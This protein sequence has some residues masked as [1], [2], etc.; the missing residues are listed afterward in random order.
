[1]RAALLLLAA[2][3]GLAG[4][5][6]EARFL[7]E[8]RRVGPNGEIVAADSAGTPREIISPA[9]IRNGFTS[10]HLV[11]KGPPG[12]SFMLYI[13][14]N[15]D[16]VLRP[17]LYRVTAPDR[18][19]PVKGLSESGKFNEHGVGLYWLDIWTPG[20]T[21]V[22]RIRVEA[23]LNV[24]KDFV[25]TPLELRVQ[26]GVVPAQALPAVARQAGGNSAAGPFALLA[27]SLCG[28]SPPA[29]ATAPPGD[30]PSILTKIVRN[31][32]Q[33]M[34]LAR[35]PA[36]AASRQAWCDQPRDAPDPE[37]YLRLR[38]AIW[39]ASQ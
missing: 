22:R 29:A 28:A 3:G 26:A 7:S 2:A 5:T 34:L 17:V 10:F 12:A 4:Q 25:I 20:P 11:A 24:G 21:P 19:E 14:S 6:L 15:P 39:R 36:L 35:K 30:S 8:F 27:H 38:D 31:A 32:G 33:D 13:A 37:S 23:Q 18:L 16:R 9:L 1:M